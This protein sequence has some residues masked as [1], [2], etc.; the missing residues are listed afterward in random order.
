[1]T[2]EYS[3]FWV[4]RL[5]RL[6]TVSVEVIGAVVPRKNLLPGGE[7]VVQRPTNDHVVIDVTDKGHDYHADTDTWRLSYAL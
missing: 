2:F 7:H 4:I 6:P 5:G 1:M 3:L